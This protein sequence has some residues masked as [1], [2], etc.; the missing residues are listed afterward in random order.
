MLG[1]EKVVW[2]LNVVAVLLVGV[3][4]KKK[5]LPS[6]TQCKEIAKHFEEVCTSEAHHSLGKS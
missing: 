1:L 6:C 3:E 4:A 5:A 2:F